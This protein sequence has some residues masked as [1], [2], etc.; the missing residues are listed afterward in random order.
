MSIKDITQGVDV[1]AKR[2]SEDA[3]KKDLIDRIGS[4]LDRRNF[5]GRT[6]VG[7]GALASG[8]VVKPKV[9]DACPI[10]CCHLCFTPP[11][12]ASTGG[13]YSNCV[14]VWTWVCCA[15]PGTKR[16]ACSECFG[17]LPTGCTAPCRLGDCECVTC[18]GVKGS[19]RQFL[20][21]F[22]PCDEEL[23]FC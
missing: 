14:C 3:M 15:Y 8:I 12:G 21:F 13:T 5:L 9:A 6:F 17:S 22:D 7:I 19:H 11:Q 4:L 23:P 1:P 18:T 2:Y 20:G 16:W 10:D